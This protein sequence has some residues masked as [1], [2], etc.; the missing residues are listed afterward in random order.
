MPLNI[1]NQPLSVQLDQALNQFEKRSL[2]T[3][4]LDSMHRQEQQLLQELPPSWPKEASLIQDHLLTHLDFYLPLFSQNFE[5]NR[6][7]LHFARSKQE[8]VQIALQLTSSSPL[9]VQSRSPLIDELGLKEALGSRLIPSHLGDWIVRLTHQLPA[10]LA[11]PALDQSVHAIAELF[12]PL[13]YQGEPDIESLVHFAKTTLRPQLLASDM[14]LTGVQ[15]GFA[16]TGSIALID[17]QG[18]TRLATSIPK[19]V[20]SFMSIEQLLPSIQ[21][22]ELFATL[23][24]VAATQTRMAPHITLLAG[25]CPKGPTT[26]HLILVDAGRSNLLATPFQSLLRC[27]GCG[28]CANTCPVYRATGAKTLYP[29]PIGSLLAPLLDPHLAPL[30]F[31]STLPPPETCPVQIPLDS[32]LIRLRENQ[33]KA[34]PLLALFGRA[35]ASPFLF[36]LFQKMI[37]WVPKRLFAPLARGRKIPQP[38]PKRLFNWWSSR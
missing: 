2:V 16:D 20:I 21:D 34:P 27:I 1:V 37:P 5:K 32:L 28:A 22:L 25:P 11:F 26:H 38:T 7:L 8:A 15:F 24:S 4:T 6:G 10:H 14:G 30:A 33:S 31:A 23:Y 17:T 9:I 18:D 3:R 35:A 19:T 36:R 29:G 12:L 13:G